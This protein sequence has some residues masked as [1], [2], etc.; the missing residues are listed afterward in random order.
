M[1]KKLVELAADIIQAQ[2]THTRMSADEISEA[3][4]KT[5]E[6]LRKIK[7]AEETNQEVASTK[8]VTTDTESKA[9]QQEEEETQ[10]KIPIDPKDSIQRTK[11]IC[12]E[13]GAEFKQLSANHLKSHGLTLREYKKKYGFPLSQPLSA[14]NLTAKRKR[15]GKKRGLPPQLIEARKKRAKA[16]SSK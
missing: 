11:V 13:C 9:A 16:A 12:L 1:S 4:L 7:N 5:F 10:K 15:I 14:K 8:E 3:L 6:T 2:A